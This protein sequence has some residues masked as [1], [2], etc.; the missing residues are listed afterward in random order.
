MK[1][2]GF[3]YREAGLKAA[4]L[5]PVGALYAAAGRLRHRL[6][7]PYR[8]SVPVICIGNLTAGGAGKT[9]T[10]IAVAERLAE[11]GRLP[12][13]LTRGY[14]GRLSGPV[15]VDLGRH[16]SPDVGDEA[17]LLAA[18][19]PTCVARD[20]RAGARAAIAAGADTLI[21]DDG[22]QNPG[23]VKDLSLIVVD[24]VSAFGNE[25]VIP[26]GPLRERI[27]EGLRRAD[28]IVLMGDDTSGIG[29]RLA[30][31]GRTLHDPPI[32]A[33]R[34]EPSGA[35]SRFRNASVVAFAGIAR[36]QKF[37]ATLEG[38]G[39]RLVARYAFGD[40]HHYDADELMQMVELADAAEAVL[41][42][43]AKDYARLPDEARLMVQV[44]TVRAVLVDPS[45]L[46][47]LLDRALAAG[48][49]N[50]S[51]PERL[52]ESDQQNEGP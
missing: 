52:S 2:P 36:P 7:S 20:R 35:A 31:I 27:T 24:G 15:L 8:A 3:W 47:P 12:A 18:R 41:V 48:T 44:L 13:F 33:A 37:F 42:T 49:A 29:M 6:A 51:A 25:R 45:G 22:F 16:S 17:L 10:A 26:A 39:A 32:L 40:H 34:L 5:A 4:L 28:A 1:A 9:P 50:A 38:L 14:R 23:I 21:M 11:R 19:F 46:D 30:A 43:T